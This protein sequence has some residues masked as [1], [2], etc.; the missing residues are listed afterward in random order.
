MLLSI[1]VPFYNVEQYV[2]DCIRSLYRQNLPMSDYEVI[3]VDDCSP[4]GSRA[5]VEKLQTEYGNLKLVVLPENRKLGGAR[6]AGLANAKGD[7]V[8]FVD[9]DDYLL[10][11]VLPQ[12]LEEIE[13]FDLDF[14]EFDYVFDI[15]GEL[16]S[17][18]R[19]LP[20]TG[21]SRGVDLF[22][23]EHF[24]WWFDH[25]VA[26]R[27]IYDKT[28]LLNNG[29]SFSEHV[30]YEDNDYALKVFAAANRVK[31]RSL[32]V[33]VYRY[34][35]NSYI[36]SH[37][38][39]EKL[40]FKLQNIFRVAALKEMLAKVDVRFCNVVDDYVRSMLSDFLKTVKDS[41]RSLKNSIS[42]KDWQK[43]RPYISLKTYLRHRYL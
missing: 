5:V 4:D 30:M 23:D 29:I 39:A 35:P 3:A 32:H 38:S 16:K 41:P 24:I 25:V 26:W 42:S 10:P 28:F 18:A 34:N 6:N 12:L 33:Y 17:N 13:R 20:D 31:H 27:K 21:I 40:N 14:L 7:Y 22:F 15:G 9:S 11:N 1:I 36:N 43:I 8:M 19:R 2:E 37:V